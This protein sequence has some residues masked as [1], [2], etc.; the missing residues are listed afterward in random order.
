MEREGEKESE[1]VGDWASFQAESSRGSDVSAHD[2]GGGGGG[3]KWKE[4]GRTRMGVGGWKT[5]NINHKVTNM[6]TDA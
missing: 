1:R 6:Y 2:R 4:K 5:V 3:T